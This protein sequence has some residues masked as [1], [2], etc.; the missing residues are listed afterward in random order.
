MTAPELTLKNIR[1]SPR[2]VESQKTTYRVSDFLIDE[3]KKARKKRKNQAK[4]TQRKFDAVDAKVAEIVA[5]FG[6]DV[7]LK[8]DNW[9]IDDEKMDRMLRAERAREK[10]YI[11]PLE[12][13][14]AHLV[15]DCIK[16]RKKEKKPTG[17]KEAA[18]IIKIEMQIATT[19]EA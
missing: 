5:R 17:P 2:L 15:K 6:Y 1:K 11:L 8:W 16:R 10:A 3:Q 4:K 13:I 12:S 19:G 9:E 18:K 14:V 7:Y